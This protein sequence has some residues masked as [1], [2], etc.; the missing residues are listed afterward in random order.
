M[1]E[2]R[3]KIIP[4]HI[5]IIMDGNGRW[6]EKKGL[7]RIEGH[8]QGRKTVKIVVRAAREFGVKILTL[9]AF[10]TENWN[11][12]KKEVK[13]LFDLLVEAIEEET[14]ELNK[15]KVKLK[16][17]GNNKILST[18]IQKKMQEAEKLTSKN[19][20]LILNVCLNYGSREEIINA[21]NKLIKEGKNNIQE[22]NLSEFLYTKGLPDPDLLIRTG[23]EKRISN[24]LLWQCAYTEFY[25]T[26]KLWPDFK[27]ND[28][29]K[30]LLEY[31]KRERRFGRIP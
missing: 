20:K 30:A 7:K 29:L 25:F 23:G 26:K 5:A 22:K 24:F 11:R 1:K 8:R 27:K 2:L 21:V 28:F 14:E 6:A 10:S 18:D 13:A 15:N 4:K 17:L 19:K 12:P 3:L 9:Y 31:G 16:F